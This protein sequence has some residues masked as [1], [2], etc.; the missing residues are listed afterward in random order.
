M[1]PRL[2][3][4]LT[5]KA[6]TSAK[7]PTPISLPLH[8]GTL[9]RRTVTV[10][11]KNLNSKQS[12]GIDCIYWVLFIAD[13]TT[14]VNPPLHGATCHSCHLCLTRS[15]W[16]PSEHKTRPKKFFFFGRYCQTG[17]QYDCGCDLKCWK[18]HFDFSSTVFESL[19]MWIL[20]QHIYDY[21]LFCCPSG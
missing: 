20:W 19:S 13:K 6:A 14:G 1:T 2:S 21:S 12:E 15:L 4:S 18:R 10:K 9:A 11:K 3:P 16:D 8:H 17:A 7:M 5:S